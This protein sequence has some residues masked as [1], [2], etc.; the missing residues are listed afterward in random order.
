MNLTKQAH[1]NLYLN[2]NPAEFLVNDGFFS[3]NAHQV[4]GA[5][6]MI[7]NKMITL[8]QFTILSKQDGAVFLYATDEKTIEESKGLI[9]VIIGQIKNKNSGWKNGKFDWGAGPTLIKKMDAAIKLTTSNNLSVFE[10]DAEGK[11]GK[12]LKTHFR[13]GTMGFSTK[14]SDS[15]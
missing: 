2:S 14:N 5:A 7:K 15:P 9:L 4:K 8:G 10:L 11:R 6:G 1:C 3:L 13:K 12:K